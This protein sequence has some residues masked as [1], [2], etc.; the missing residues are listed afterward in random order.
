M[1][2]LIKHIL[3]ESS[4]QS[5][6]LDVIVE[7]GIFD[8]ADM[9]G[10]IDNLK[11]IFKDNSKII[12]R[13]NALEGK[14]L[15]TLTFDNGRHVTLPFKV[16]VIG[17][18]TTSRG[19]SWPSVNVKYDRNKFNDFENRQIESFILD[20]EDQGAYE[21]FLDNYEKFQT[22]YAVQIEQINGKVAYTNEYVRPKYDIIRD[23]EDKLTELNSHS[24][25]SEDTHK[26]EETEGAGG[27]EAPAFEMEPD[28]VHF[29]HLY[30]ESEITEKCWKGYTQKGMK[31]MFGKK[32]P[33][34]VKMKKKK[35][36]KESIKNVLDEEI[37]KKYAKPTEKINKLVYNW[38]DG[39]F[40]GSQMYVN[41]VWK[42][43]RFDF[44]FCKGGKE[45]ASASFEFNDESPDWGDRDA[46]PL[47]ERNFESSSMYV[48]PTLLDEVQM[49][50]PIRRNYLKYLI[51]EWFEDMQLEK[52]QNILKRNDLSI[53]KVHEITYES[54]PICVPPVEKPE[55]VSMDD[56]IEYV[57][58]NTLFSREDLESH[59][60]DQPG[61]IERIYLSKLRDE[62]KKRLGDN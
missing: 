29:K 62:E 19:N 60:D 2:K 61:W 54:Q 49:D 16:E 28:H 43:H 4:I 52:I 8:A 39:Y 40:D 51:E 56:M 15:M 23:I 27:Y 18:Q 31:T 7:D 58:D 34:C 45:I 55:D 3:K 35:S 38:L 21:P 22:D 53:D 48:Y 9:V 47:S 24:N 13:I 6:L 59:E 10:G 57:M 5:R 1:K 25:K 26:E 36:L 17:K 30:N 50:I 32:Y 46:R 14:L 20:A 42:D 41:E 37:G 11:R 12:D 44:E 33:N